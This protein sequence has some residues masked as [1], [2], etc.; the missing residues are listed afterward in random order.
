V[1]A[2]FAVAPN[3]QCKGSWVDRLLVAEG[4]GWRAPDASELV[5]L[6]QTPEDAAACA[7]LFSVPMHVRT[8]FWAMLDEEAAEGSGDFVSFSDDLAQFLTFKD[9]P[10]PK[11]SV[12]EL[13]VQDA[14]GKVTTGDVWALINFGEEPLLL[15]W[16]KL[17]L[18]LN[19]GEGFQTA[20]G[21]PPDVVPPAND[22]FNALVAIR[23]TSADN[24]QMFGEANS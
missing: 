12:C 6:T 8:R 21:S 17:Q 20:A 4:A 14:R 10:P 7:T 15:A 13:L 9:L 22:E 23:L 11:D 24:A 2:S 18:R 5:S 3:F 1:T 19:P 16:P